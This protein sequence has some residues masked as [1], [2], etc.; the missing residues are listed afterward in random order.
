MF[1]FYNKPSRCEEREEP[2]SGTLELPA[3]GRSMFVGAFYD[4]RSNEVVRPYKE[5]TPDQLK[6]FEQK[7][8][9]TNIIL[10]DSFREK[11][12]ALGLDAPL[13]VSVLVDLVKVDAA[14]KYI[15]DRQPLD[16]QCRITLHIKTTK[17][18]EFVTLQT[19]EA[20]LKGETPDVFTQGRATHVVSSALYGSNTFIVLDY[21]GSDE[22]EKAAKV[23]KDLVRQIEVHAKEGKSRPTPAGGVDHVQCRVYSDLTPECNP[24]DV[25]A[26][27]T[28][29][30]SLPRLAEE[31]FVLTKVFV[32]PLIKIDPRSS[33]VFSSISESVTAQMYTFL[34]GLDDCLIRSHELARDPMCKDFPQMQEKLALFKRLLIEFR[35]MYKKDMRHML[36]LIVGG[37][38]GEGS[39]KDMFRDV[40][41]SPFNLTSMKA[42]VQSKHTELR[43]IRA[44]VNVFPADVEIVNSQDTLENILFDPRVETVVCFTFQL[45]G[46][47]EDYLRVLSGYIA[48]ER[49]I[50]S[51][52]VTQWYDDM[53]LMKEMRPKAK[54]FSD[55]C[56]SNKETVSIKFIETGFKYR[57]PGS[58]EEESSRIGGTVFLF[59]QG[60]LTQEDFHPPSRPLKPQCDVI[61]EHSVSLKW[62]P[63]EYGLS[64]VQ[65]YAIKYSVFRGQNAQTC[66]PQEM[67]TESL[68]TQVLIDNLEPNQSIRFQVSAVC[69][70][71]VGPESERSAAASP[72]SAKSPEKPEFRNVTA[73]S[74]V[75]EWKQ[76][77]KMGKDG[78]VESYIIQLMEAGN[79]INEIDIKSSKKEFIIKDLEANTTYT[80]QVVAL[81][82]TGIKSPPSTTSDNCTTHPASRPGKPAVSDV[83][84]TSVVITWTDP[85]TVAPGVELIDHFIQYR[86][87]ANCKQSTKSEDGGWEKYMLKK[88]GIGASSCLIPDLDPNTT[89]VA[90]VTLVCRVKKGNEPE[91]IPSAISVPFTTLPAGPPRG[92]RAQQVSTSQIEIKWTKPTVCGAEVKHY[93]VEYSSDDDSVVVS[94]QTYDSSCKFDI[95]GVKSKT[96]Y[97][98]NVW[99]LCG[100]AGAGEVSKVD[101]TTRKLIKEDVIKL[102]KRLQPGDPNTGKPT[103][104]ELPLEKVCEKSKSRSYSFGKKPKIKREHKVFMVVG[105]TGSGK[106]TL[107]NAMV[108][109]IL[110]VEWHDKYRFKMVDVGEGNGSSQVHSQTQVL[111]SY[112][113]T[114]ENL[115]VPYDL[116][117]VDTPGFGD[118]RG[119]Q[120]DKEI[121]DQ[122]REFFL[123]A[124]FHGIDHIDAIGFVVKAP[125]VRL[126]QTQQYVFDSILS[127]FGK[128]VADNIILLATFA[129]GKQPPVMAAVIEAKIPFTGHMFKFNNSALFAEVRQP[130]HQGG[131]K[132]S[133]G[134]DHGMF[135]TMFWDMGSTNFKNFFQKVK[136]LE[137]RSLILT[138]NVLEERKRLETA[139]QG[140]QP[141]IKVGNCKYESLRKEQQILK[142]HEVQIE[143]NKNFK[144]TVKNPKSKKVDI[145]GE[146]ITNCS[147]C[148]FTCHYPCRIADDA[149]KAG[150]AAM[151]DGVCTVCPGKCPWDVHFNQQYKFEFYEEEEEKTYEEIEARFKDASGKKLTVQ[152]VIKKHMESLK[153]VRTAVFALIAE[154]HKSVTRLEEIALKPNP[155][156]TVEY[157]DLLIESEK[158]SGKPG[159]KDRVNSLEGVRKDADTIGKVKHA[160]YDPFENFEAEVQKKKEKRWRYFFLK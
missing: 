70:A 115:N 126:T 94:K 144:F 8:R 12:L 13:K 113:L 112:T 50:S 156:S 140:L 96:R 27:F 157:I 69:S 102:S 54:L 85:T 24:I 101:C 145:T 55:F 62:T 33:R 26:L 108:N 129:D 15:H 114:D 53:A 5:T 91:M 76:P 64:N 103:I 130:N 65:R 28:F 131:D 93:K 138:V 72:L 87:V 104:F 46:I 127:V 16:S 11:S 43:A 32:Y 81:Y 37:S 19:L 123:D 84:S 151:R 39:I 29:M 60:M 2:I 21:S 63:P 7:E 89:Y 10:S 73:S 79:K 120:R 142:E 143:A 95:E 48:P 38:E 141:Q 20:N 153:E 117:I 133:N 99:G 52:K 97:N 160:N 135:D 132:T 83:K 42:W 86:K 155:L 110:E 59:E 9:E 125:D 47:E 149:K 49:R 80:F 74:V 17:K 44:Y 18:L 150:C 67:Q 139:V 4:C 159:W 34:E 147:K 40:D 3:L 30:A 66:E 6:V 51:Y 88:E 119:I 56:E 154:A 106:S 45:N 92:L 57:K 36:P 136:S 71:G 31:K 124:E 98:I 25:N 148:H 78:V 75:L 152:Q 105:V 100:K 82:K 14:A 122:I 118:T 116:T 35:S 109:N 22:E 137:A 146:Y 41:S 1:L 61:D 58:S 111:T 128:D 90:R 107:I 23:L 77:G 68:E 134:K 121:L 158:H